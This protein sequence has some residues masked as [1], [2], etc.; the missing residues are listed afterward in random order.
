[1][2]PG[3]REALIVSAKE[4]VTGL[5]CCVRARVNP[6]HLITADTSWEEL[7]AALIVALECADPWKVA[8]LAEVPSDDGLAADDH[9]EAR[10]WLLN[11][12]HAQVARLRGDG[13]P[14]PTRLALLEVEYQNAHP[15]RRVFGIGADRSWLRGQAALEQTA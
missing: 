2:T 5:A 10:E 3:E 7:A 1:M 14:L 11:A 6:G 12:A 8:R 9:V 4:L 15:R 13:R